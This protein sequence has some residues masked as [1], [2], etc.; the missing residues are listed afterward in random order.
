[1]HRAY[2]CQGSGP[3][4]SAQDQIWVSSWKI[5]HLTHC[6]MYPALIHSLLQYFSFVLC[7]PCYKSCYYCLTLDQ[8][9]IHSHCY[10]FIHLF[11]LHFR[12][13]FWDNFD[14]YLLQL[15]TECQ[16]DNGKLSN[17]VQCKNILV[18]PLLK[19][20]FCTQNFRLTVII[21]L[22]S[23]GCHLRLR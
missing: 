23:S 8:V 22:L 1:M 20:F 13:I 5:Q 11:F 14:S 6:T 10:H 9:F 7:E 15:F 16:V 3:Y 12:K 4:C 19:E 18:S 21:F 17:C 2:S